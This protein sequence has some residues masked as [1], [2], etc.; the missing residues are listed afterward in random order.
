MGNPNGYIYLG[1]PAM[2]AYSALTG[3]IS[4]PREIYALNSSQRVYPF[5]KYIN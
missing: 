3:Y 4:D 2:A 1:S 5:E